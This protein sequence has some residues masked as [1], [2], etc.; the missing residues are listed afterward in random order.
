LA[1]FDLDEAIIE[2]ICKIIANHHSARNIDTI[3]FRIIWDADW[4]V[5]I[6]A[7]FKDA[8]RERLKQ[9]IN[10]VFKTKEGHRIAVQTLL[11]ADGINSGDVEAPVT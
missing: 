5:N 3:E 8:N 10:K 6:P 9:L 4:L 2:H 1:K 7:D 11:S